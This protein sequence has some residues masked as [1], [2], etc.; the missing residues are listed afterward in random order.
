M[1]EDL[2]FETLTAPEVA[3]YAALL[4]GLMFGAIAQITRFCFRRAL[5]GED[6]KDALALWLTALSVAVLGTQALV[7]Y[8]VIDL[9]EHRFATASIPILAIVIGGLLFGA[10]MVLTRGCVSRLTV[11]TASGNMRALTVLLVFGFVAHATMKGVLS[12]LRTWFTKSTYDLPFETAYLSAIPN[13]GIF[14]GLA[15]TS[16]TGLLVVRS[17]NSTLNVALVVLLSALVPLAFATTG[18]VLLDDF[19]PIATEGLSFTAP[20]ADGLFFT[21]ASTAITPNFGAGLIGGVL[22]GAFA[23]ALI[24][25]EFN[26]QSFENNAEMGRYLTGAIFMGFGGVMAG[27]CTVG[28]GL[29]GIPT[30]SIAAILATGAIALGALVM[31]RVLERTTQRTAPIGLQMTPAE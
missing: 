15:L 6:R 17:G 19:D 31:K 7:Y 30:L 11:L 22:I 28:A 29:S 8:E 20:I 18:F 21:I 24:R 27:G 12:P 2:G 25:R 3:V 14:F 10:G 13:F 23:S 16:V 4:I 1:F 5:V 26:W 9:S